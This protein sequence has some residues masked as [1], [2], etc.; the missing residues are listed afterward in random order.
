MENEQV[1]QIVQASSMETNQGEMARPPIV[2]LNIGAE[3]S[4]FHSENRKLCS[5]V[6]S[7]ITEGPSSTGSQILPP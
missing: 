3:D 2:R 5:A 7:V 4:G 6:R 1:S